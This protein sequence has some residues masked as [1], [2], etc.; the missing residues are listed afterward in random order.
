MSIIV[1]CRVCRHEYQVGRD[2]LLRGVWRQCPVCRPRNP[3]ET[4][5]PSTWDGHS[6]TRARKARRKFTETESGGTE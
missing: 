3:P 1:E 2:D 4:E 6:G 5:K